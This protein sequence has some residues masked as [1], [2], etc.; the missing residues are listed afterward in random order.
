MWWDTAATIKGQGR[1][2]TMACRGMSI[3]SL[4]MGWIYKKFSILQQLRPFHL[5]YINIFISV[6]ESRNI[7]NAQQYVENLTA[8]HIEILKVR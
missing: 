5:F 3:A 1:R 8:R 6:P 7:T 2:G 4:P